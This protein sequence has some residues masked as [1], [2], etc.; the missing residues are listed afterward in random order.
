MIAREWKFTLLSNFINSLSSFSKENKLSQNISTW[1]TYLRQFINSVAIFLPRNSDLTHTRFTPHLTFCLSSESRTI[2][3]EWI[4]RLALTFG[5]AI[6]QPRTVSFRMYRN[7][8]IKEKHNNRHRRIINHEI[9][10]FKVPT[11][12]DDSKAYPE[13]I[14]SSVILRSSI[15]LLRFL[16]SSECFTR[17]IKSVWSGPQRYTTYFSNWAL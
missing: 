8:W 11:M 1:W 17:I 3:S 16:A 6:K 13:P 7:A 2:P 4:I 10:D 9:K 15:T 12:N 5:S 14:S